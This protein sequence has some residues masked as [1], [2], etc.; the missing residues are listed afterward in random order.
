MSPTRPAQM[1]R[2]STGGQFPKKQ[3]GTLPNRRPAKPPQVDAP[4]TSLMAPPPPQTQATVS[5][6]GPV[7]L[8]AELYQHCASVT[9]YIGWS[10]DTIQNLKKEVDLA[11]K[12]K[13]LVSKE[14]D[15]ASKERDLTLKEL[16]DLQED[17][18]KCQSELE[19]SQKN[20]GSMQEAI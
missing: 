10:D 13:D 3:L 18:S 11:V 14:R 12:E 8:R 4:R 17:L 1:A 19:Q 2:K 6:E 15:L 9:T 5:K 7:N 16:K 20:Y